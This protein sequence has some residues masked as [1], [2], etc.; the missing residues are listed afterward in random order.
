MLLHALPPNPSAINNLVGVALWGMVLVVLARSP[1]WVRLRMSAVGWALL[2]LLLAALAGPFFR[3]VPWSVAVNALGMLLAA[4]LVLL[5][6]QR[7][8]PKN[9]SS[10]FEAL[11]VGALLAASLNV[12]V[13]WIQL[14]AS[15]WTGGQSLVSSTDTMG[16]STGN[17]RQPNHLATL[18]VW[19]M[20]AAVYLAE[21]GRWRVWRKT[22]VLPLLVV[23]MV[24]TLV[25]S[26]SRT[27]MLAVLGLAAWGALDKQLARRTRWV[28]MVSPLL[29]MAGWFVLGGLADYAGFELMWQVRMER[30]G[31]GSVERLLIWRNAW[32]LL[33][34]HPW[35]GV[36]WGEFNL[37]WALTPMAERPGGVYNHVHNLPLHLAVELGVP[38]AVLVLGLCARSCWVLWK[39]AR[40]AADRPGGSTLMARCT[41]GWLAMV[42]LH[43]MLEFPLWYAYFLLPMA[44]ALGLALPLL[45]AG[46]ANRVVVNS[47]NASQLGY[48][49][50]VLGLA[51]LLG[52]LW[53]T[54]DYVRV[55]DIYN[56]SR[57]PM[58][59]RISA[60]QQGFFFQQHVDA[61]VAGTRS[62]QEALEA[63][64]R[65]A[66]ELTGPDSMFYWAKALHE[67]GDDDRARYLIARMR[68]FPVPLLAPWFAE[69]EKYLQ[70]EAVRPF[71]CDPPSRN[72]TLEE[73]R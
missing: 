66:H 47:Q 60:A 22:W 40:P 57:V 65:A 12:M 51:L 33:L 41:L 59:T 61:V 44:F 3:G 26:A 24:F 38:M 35:L 70:E 29:Y 55:A 56:R 37:A 7:V 2:L 20:V 6:A 27:G 39:A 69:C 32:D 48:V 42:G 1:S 18:L 16:R 54:L 23:L 36:G 25:L 71:Q 62:G 13:S 45:G 67:V 11:V 4:L 64:R 52:A 50:A 28:L 10:W 17:L 53:A 8:A 68:E 73:L 58:Q 9:R 30:Q 46:H 21:A 31:M 34:Q 14:F 63:A 43:S 49:Q 72:Y 19:G 5:A 15:D